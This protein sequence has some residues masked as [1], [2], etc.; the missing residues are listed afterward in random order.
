MYKLNGESI[1]LAV[2]LHWE[3]QG[4]C[5]RKAISHSSRRL[6]LVPSFEG[7]LQGYRVQAIAG[8]LH[9]NLILSL[10]KPR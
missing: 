4:F 6:H 2:A 10:A 5:S 8:W 3:V 1:A 9:L 7:E